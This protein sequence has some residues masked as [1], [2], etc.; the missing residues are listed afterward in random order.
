MLVKQLN[1]NSSNETNISCRTSVDPSGQPS[2]IRLARTSARPLAAPSCRPSGDLTMDAFSEDFP[3]E[4][5]WGLKLPCLITILCHHCFVVILKRFSFP[6]MFL[7]WWKRW[8][9]TFVSLNV[10]TSCFFDRYYWQRAR[11]IRVLLSSQVSRLLHK[12]IFFLVP[13]TGLACL[14]GWWHVEGLQKE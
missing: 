14:H 7:I 5:S 6:L 13:L 10:A 8:P 11:A 3:G 9:A 1:P 2:A 4:T 12:K